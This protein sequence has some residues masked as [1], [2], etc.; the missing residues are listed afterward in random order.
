MIQAIIKK[1]TEAGVG[2][3]VSAEGAIDI[4][5]R[6]ED[7]ACWL[8]VLREHKADILA[9][10]QGMNVS[11]RRESA[12]VKSVTS[13]SSVFRPPLE[14]SRRQATLQSSAGPLPLEAITMFRVGF[15]WITAHLTELLVAG[16]SRRELYGRGRY[17]WPI[18]DWGAVWTLPFGQPGKNPGHWTSGEI[19]FTF[20]NGHGDLVRQTAWPVKLLLSLNK[21]EG[22]QQ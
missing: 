17:R 15:P 6:K 9:A 5:G 12:Q 3:A 19:V 11:T 1:V 20:A 13:V 16:W 2:I 18:G 10:L 21:E 4:T 8:P 14:K 7:V 22:Q